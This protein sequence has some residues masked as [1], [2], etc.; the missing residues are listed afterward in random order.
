MSLDPSIILAIE[1]AAN[2]DPDNMALRSHLASLLLAAGRCPEALDA[3]RVVLSRRPDDFQTLDIAARSAE[4]AGDLEVA[5]GYRKLH[6]ALGWKQTQGML[7][8]FEIPA[9]PSDQ[10]KPGDRRS[11]DV[12]DADLR[13]PA[14]VRP[15]GTIAG[16]DP[17]DSMDAWAWNA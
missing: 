17:P 11:A 7:N 12:V 16:E 8:G 15:D 1:A 6:Q 5:A 10:A 2:A 4:I 14:R 3:C 9:M 13:T